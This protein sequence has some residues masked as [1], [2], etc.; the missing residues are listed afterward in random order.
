[1]LCFL[2]VWITPLDANFHSNVQEITPLLICLWI[3]LWIEFNIG[4]VGCSKK[5]IWF[6]IDCHLINIFTVENMI[7]CLQK[8]AQLIFYNLHVC[9]IIY[10]MMKKIWIIKSHIMHALENIWC[11][12][13]L[14]F[15]VTTVTKK[16]IFYKLCPN[17]RSSKRKICLEVRQLEFFYSPSPSSFN[18]FSHFKISLKWVW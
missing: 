13:I 7:V 17:P 15:E 6:Q 10:R 16:C 11:N 4:H 5:I 14:R 1:M 3:G 12:Y 8:W 2:C 18:V 9:I